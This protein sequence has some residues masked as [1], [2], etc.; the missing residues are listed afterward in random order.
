MPTIIVHTL[1]LTEDQKRFLAEQYT[2]LLGET[3]HMPTD[4][5]YVLFNGYAL[6]SLAVNGHLISETPPGP[7]AWVSKYTVDLKRAQ[8]EGKNNPPD[9]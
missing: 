1:E 3:L 6:E 5:I 8:A 4:R 9:G 2:T 7:D